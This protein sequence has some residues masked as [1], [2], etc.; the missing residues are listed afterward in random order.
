MV[1]APEGPD[2]I[3][4]TAEV[5]PV[6]AV[7]QWLVLPSCGAIVTF[8]GTARDHAPGRPDVE[9]LKYEA[10]EEPALRRMGEVALEARRRWPEL[11][12]LA[13]L[14]RVGEVAISDAAVVVGASSAHRDAAFAAARWTIDAVKASVPI[15]KHETWSG[16]AQWGT[17]AQ[18]LLTPSDVSGPPQ[19]VSS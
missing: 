7:A 8:A 13:L 9:R 4:L 14:H 2:W 6:D 16:G 12:R 18:H 17:D 11:G 10:Y 15:W 1:H 19:D 3:G 5:L